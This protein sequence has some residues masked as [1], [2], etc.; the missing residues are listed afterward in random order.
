[1]MTQL[2]LRFF[3]I[4]IFLFFELVLS[5]DY[6]LISRRVDIMYNYV[7]KKIISCYYT[8]EHSPAYAEIEI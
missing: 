8:I 6:I 1:M 7:S 4:F 5:V 3:N 2:R